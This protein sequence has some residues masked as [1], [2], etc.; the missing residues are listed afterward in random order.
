[1]SGFAD[2]VAGG[3]MS[4]LEGWRIY[5]RQFGP[6][7]GSPVTLIHGYPTSSHDW[8]PIIPALVSVGLRVTVLDLLG[9]GAS[10]KPVGHAFSLLE[11]TAIVTALWHELGISSTALVAHDYGVSVAQELLARDPQR[12]TRA[13]FLNGGLYPDLHRPIRVQRLLHSPAGA[14]LG[15]LSSEFMYRRTFGEILGRPLPAEMLHEM[16]L[17]TTANGGR[18]VQHD[19]LRYIDERR[20]LSGRWVRALEGYDGPL[21]FVWGPADPI[22]GAHVLVR[23]RERLPQATF[24]G[25]D[26]APAVGHYPQLEDPQRVGQALADFLTA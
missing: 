22:S 25:L 4:V 21:A 24:V 14:V 15:P 17:A 1:M 2:W 11:Q 3:E 7:D 9:F 16:W 26:D 12:I 18:W 8:E 19:L 5:A 13:A 10:E 20:E 6:P 23:L